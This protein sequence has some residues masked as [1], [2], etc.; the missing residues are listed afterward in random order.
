ML[1]LAKGTMVTILFI[2][3]PHVAYGPETFVNQ[4]I[5]RH[6][7]FYAKETERIA[8]WS[9]PSRSTDHLVPTIDVRI[10]VLEVSLWS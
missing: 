4:S 3:L 5:G 8:Y 1:F 9:V 7:P 6:V 2:S 10:D